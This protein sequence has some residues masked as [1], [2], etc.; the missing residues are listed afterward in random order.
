MIE[1]VPPKNPEQHGTEPST[2]VAAM[3]EVRGV[4][5]KYGDITVL[6][7]VSLSCG[8]GQAVALLGP[9]G[10]G[11]TTMLRVIAGL[12]RPSA[13]DVIVAGESVNGY[14]AS[15]RSRRG[16]CHIPEGRGIFPTLSVR[17]NLRLFLPKETQLD[18]ILDKVEAA[19]PVLVS[20]LGQAAGRLSGGEQQ[21]LAVMRA[22]ISNP[23]CVLVDEASLGLAPKVVDA[24]FEF[25]QQVA[26]TGTSLVIVEQYI[27]RALALADTVYLLSQGQVVFAG[28]SASVNGDEIFQ[29][30]L[31]LDH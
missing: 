21:M 25:L 15:Q 16:I 17:E 20:R 1:S 29:Q 13:G 31:G 12:L 10:A 30:Y 28:P 23:T 14:S 18:E 22:Y 6:H 27:D 26:K 8:T 4:S 19:F 7:D 11:K 2:A 24:L 5:A 9:N 3:L